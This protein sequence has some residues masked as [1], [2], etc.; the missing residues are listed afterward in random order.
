MG[1]RIIGPGLPAF[2]VAELSGNHKQSFE[3][4]ANLIRA[5]K[6]CGADAVKL[7][8]Y[9]A[10]TMTIACDS[11]YFRVSG[12][13]PWDDR[14]LH[15]LYGE[16][17]TPW[18]WQPDLQKIAQDLDLELFSTPFDSSAVEF[19]ETLNM[20]AY[21]IASFEMVDLPL[22]EKVARTGKP[23]IISTGMATEAEIEAAVQAARKAGATQIALL[24]CTSSYPADPGQMNLRTIPY[25]AEKFQMPVG[26]SDHTLG[27]AIPAAAVALGACIIEKHLTLSR[28]AG[29]PDSA[30]SLEPEEFAAMVDAVRTAERAL[31]CVSFVCDEKEA[32]MRNYRRSIFLT[33]N[34]SAGNVLTPAN[35][36]IIRPGHGLAPAHYQEVL[37]R[38][39]KKDVKRGTPLAWDLLD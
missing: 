15:N 9:T 30:F 2:I 13:T 17:F 38:R 23:L 32:R 5:A 35:I 3:E 10:D 21:K 20:P 27:V 11:E 31:G 37:G 28:S 16:A 25:L 8:T 18:E 33:E 26:L 4:A 34:V 36:R 19:L 39:V 22:I 7:Q 6:E 14:T 1:T 29:G 24:K 12:G